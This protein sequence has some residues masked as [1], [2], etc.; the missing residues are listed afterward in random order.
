MDWQTLAT[1]KR[2][3]RGLRTASWLTRSFR[4]WR[5]SCS[6]RRRRSRP[7][8]LWPGTETTPP[9]SAYA[10]IEHLL[11]SRLKARQRSPFEHFTRLR[12]ADAILARRAFDGS[13]RAASF[14]HGRFQ[15]PRLFYL[16]I[17]FFVHSWD[18]PCGRYD[19][20]KF[21]PINSVLFD[22]PDPS[23]FTVLT[24]PSHV[25]GTAVADFV[26]F[27]PRWTVAQVGVKLRDRDMHFDHKQ[28]CSCTA[29]QAEV[30][31]IHFVRSYVDVFIANSGRT[32]TLICLLF[33][34]RSI[35]SAR[36]T[37]TATPC[38]SSWDS[39]GART[40]QSRTGFCRGARR[41]TSA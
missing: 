24:C 13:L 15:H 38:P 40:R 28:R 30:G 7:S 37:T 2:R 32:G 29:D 23:I 3:W 31:C 8:T 36:R 22:H 35:P 16:S 17:I 14:A 6:R 11:L 25:P 19:L 41:C 33:P 21:C 34:I 26:I 39:S 5:G 18:C 4:N 27:P 1:F 10:D 12:T 20:A 9:T